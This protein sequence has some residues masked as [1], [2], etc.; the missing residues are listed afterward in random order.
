MSLIEKALGKAKVTPVTVGA[1]TAASARR[2]DAD[3]EA[4]E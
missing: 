1:E 4:R 2:A 3:A